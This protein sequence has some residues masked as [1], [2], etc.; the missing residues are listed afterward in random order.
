MTTKFKKLRAHLIR[1]R[2]MSL[3]SKE[4]NKYKSNKLEHQK[5]RD[6]LIKLMITV[7]MDEN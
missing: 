6:Q 2:N 4:I 3:F 5:L 1:I 7:D